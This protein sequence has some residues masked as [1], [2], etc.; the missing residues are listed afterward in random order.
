MDKEEGMQINGAQVLI[1]VFKEHGVDTV[2]GYPGGA[3]LDIYDEL[4]KASDVIR[5]VITCH[6]QGAAHAADGYA[7]ATGR[8]GVVIATSGPGAT[9]LV[10]G[11]A[12]AYLD[13][14]P[15]VAITGNVACALIG[16]DSFQEVDIT[17]ITMPITKCNFLVRSVEDLADVVREAPCWWISPRMCSAASVSMNTASPPPRT[18]AGP[19]PRRRWRR[20]GR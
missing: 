2:F 11:I 20:Q 18:A 6:E 3:V 10:T 19:C 1:E 12:N 9:N 8:T 15:M 13:S 14:V 16:R 7:R 4:Y 17:G 5:H